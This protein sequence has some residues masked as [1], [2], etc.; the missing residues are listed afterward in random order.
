MACP[1]S[2][3]LKYPRLNPTRISLP[4]DQIPLLAGQPP[5][6]PDSLNTTTLFVLAERCEKPG[7]AMARQ[8]QDSIV[9]FIALLLL[10]G[11]K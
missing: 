5:N 11:L 10:L 3:F 8:T 2:L 1:R 4:H 7:A 9:N 6:R